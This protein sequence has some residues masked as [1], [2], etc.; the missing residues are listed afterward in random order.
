MKEFQY[1]PR[2]PEK[3]KQRARRRVKRKP[4]VSLDGVTREL[5]TSRRR[6]G[7]KDQPDKPK[8]KGAKP[9]R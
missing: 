5:E 7:L 2:D 9:R 3:L 6:D 4:K 8:P 1:V